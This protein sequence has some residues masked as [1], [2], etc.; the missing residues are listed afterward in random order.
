[1]L[2]DRPICWRI[3][4]R[5]TDMNICEAERAVISMCQSVVSELMRDFAEADALLRDEIVRVK[6]GWVQQ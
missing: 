3:I 5:T 4:P 6:Y 2:T 1:M